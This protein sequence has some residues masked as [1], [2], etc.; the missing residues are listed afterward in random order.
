MSK[1]IFNWPLFRILI[2]KKKHKQPPQP[3]KLFWFIYGVR[4]YKSLA[5]DIEYTSCECE[6]YSAG[7]RKLFSFIINFKWLRQHKR[8]M[9]YIFTDAR[10]SWMW[11]KKLKQ[12]WG[13]LLLHALYI[14]FDRQC[15]NTN[16]LFLN[17]KD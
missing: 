11:L 4:C 3:D 2:T 7:K 1:G 15:V 8:C 16:V 10:K 6:V 13:K 17:G 5:T 14:P 12:R 9:K